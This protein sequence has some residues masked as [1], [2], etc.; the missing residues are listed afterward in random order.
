[1][2]VVHGGI[3]VGK[4]MGLIPSHVQRLMEWD[5]MLTTRNQEIQRKLAESTGILPKENEK[6]RHAASKTI[7]SPL[8]GLKFSESASVSKRRR[9]SLSSKGKTLSVFL[10]GLKKKDIMKEIKD[11]RERHDKMVLL[12]EKKVDLRPLPEKF[13]PITET[14][15]P[16]SSLKKE[17]ISDFPVTGVEKGEKDLKEEM[18]SRFAEAEDL[19][20][21]KVDE[22]RK[23]DAIVDQ[24]LGLDRKQ[25]VKRS[26]C[27]V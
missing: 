19:M 4:G 3:G 14:F 16:Y 1:M 7:S 21:N 11:G 8:E 17:N 26:C 10:N 18:K 12:R 15:R 22:E 2:K 20:K 13:V 23:E 25:F 5:N 9:F 27:L 6:P 24:I